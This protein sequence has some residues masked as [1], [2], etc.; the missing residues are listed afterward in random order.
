VKAFISR[1]SQGI[2]QIGEKTNGES[3]L[4]FVFKLIEKS[5]SINRRGLTDY[6]GSTMVSPSP[7]IDIIIAMFENM[8]GKINE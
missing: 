7:A 2:L 1:D 5:L 4:S 3:Y 6:C 8:Q